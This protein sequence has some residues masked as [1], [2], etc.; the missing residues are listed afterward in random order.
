[1]LHLLLCIS[2]W[3]TVASVVAYQT[4]SGLAQGTKYLKKLHSIPCAN[5]A[6]FTGDYRLKCPLCP[7]IALSE[8][9]IGCRDFQPRESC[10]FNNFQ[11]K[12][13]LISCKNIK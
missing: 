4:I 8:L 2:I 9:A 6:Y 11:S 10:N 12:K 5:C 13:N 7:K 1:M 3:V